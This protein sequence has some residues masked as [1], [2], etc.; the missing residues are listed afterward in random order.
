VIKQHVKGWG[1]WTFTYTQGADGKVAQTDVVDPD[2]LHR[3]VVF[4]ADGYP[5]SDAMFVGQPEERVTRF[6]RAP[7]GNVVARITVECRS[8]SGAPASVTAP[9]ESESADAVEERLHD[10]CGQQREAASTQ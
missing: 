9:V 10:Q 8:A 2:G 4:N 7:G 5:Q 3:R 6:E 1:S